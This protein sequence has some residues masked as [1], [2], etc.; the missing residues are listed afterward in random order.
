MRLP[1][2]IESN[3]EP[4]LAEWER[5]ARSLPLGAHMSAKELRDD[6]EDLLR[7]TVADMRSAQ[8]G[9]EQQA[10]SEGRGESSDHSDR[11]DRSSSAHAKERAAAGFNLV[12]LISEYRALR[13]SVLR[14]WR[15]SQPLPAPSDLDDLTRFNESID[16]SLSVA[17]NSFVETMDLSRQ[18]FLAI[19]GHDLRGPLNAMTMSTEL[20]RRTSP[21]ESEAYGLTDLLR[22]STASM[23][24][25]VNDLLD[26][27]STA[28]GGVM[29]ISPVEMDLTVLCADVVAEIRAGHPHCKISYERGG[30][31]SGLWDPGRLRQVL[32]NLLENAVHHGDKGCV[33]ELSAGV[34][35]EDAVLR[36]TN[37]GPPIAPAILATLF[38]PLTRARSAQGRRK[39]SMGLGLYIARQ[40]VTSHGGTIDVTSTAD[41]G[42]T[43]TVRLPRKA[44]SRERG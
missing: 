11:L 26:F 10:K 16:Q 20:L 38:D 6:A 1:E 3:I 14:L 42:T 32:S 37:S 31:I 9:D 29:P 7:R 4:I 25:I 30:E 36:V 17:V 27:T 22:S 41:K 35:G 19:L 44:R 8:T 24:R 13:A 40:V 23:G 21:P 34:E 2:F 12:A 33:I 39:G 28:L 43:F 5:F 18:M 15:Q